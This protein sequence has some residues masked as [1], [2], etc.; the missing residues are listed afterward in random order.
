MRSQR[1]I[2]QYLLDLGL[3]VETD[4]YGY[5]VVGILRVEKAERK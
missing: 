1:I 5:S 2:K 3:E 4:I